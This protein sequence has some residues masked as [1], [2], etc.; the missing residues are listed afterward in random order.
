[1]FMEESEGDKTTLLFDSAE[2]ENISLLT[3]L[4]NEEIDPNS[5]IFNFHYL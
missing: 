1:M 5:E 2:N 3:K 4:L